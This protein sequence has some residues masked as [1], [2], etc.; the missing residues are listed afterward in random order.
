MTQT[1]REEKI[2]ELIAFE[3]DI[4]AEFNAGKIKAPVHLYSDNEETMVDYF[5]KNVKPDDWVLCT[6]RS[7]YQC[8]LKGVDK[9]VL[10]QDIMD[11]KSITLCYPE[12]NIFSSAIV[13]G[14]IPIATGIGMGIKRDGGK[15][16][17]HCFVGDMTSMTGSFHENFTYCWNHDIPVNFV[18]ED[19][20]K[21]VCTD[22]RE[23]WGAPKKGTLIPE[24]SAGIHKKG[25]SECSLIYYRYK[26]K[27]PHAGAGQ[28]VQF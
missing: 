9:K 8:L 11:G 14:I 10:K 27:Y 24:P 23:V 12:H 13:T 15:G 18:I 28:R 2:A 22:T 4:A 3:D 19:N 16:R 20:D 6:W 1:K 5:D 17:V 25:P 21:S 7:H 26:N